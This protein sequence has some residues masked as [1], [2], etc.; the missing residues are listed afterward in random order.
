VTG[1]HWLPPSKAGD[2]R[3]VPVE[4]TK[5]MIEAAIIKTLAYRKLHTNV[6]DVT[7]ILAD[8]KLRAVDVLIAAEE[9]GDE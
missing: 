1:H 3:T 5:E 4:P 9:N 6:A 2:H 7:K 8:L